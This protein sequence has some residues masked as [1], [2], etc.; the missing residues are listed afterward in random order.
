[1]ALTEGYGQRGCVK[2]TDIIN[3]HNCKN[4]EKCILFTM[5][6]PFKGCGN[7]EKSIRLSRISM[8]TEDSCHHEKSQKNAQNFR[9]VLPAHVCLGQNKPPF[10]GFCSCKILE[11]VGAEHMV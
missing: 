2:D 10:P 3:I 1:M 6:T 9:A 7:R 11:A 5:E 4:I 8:Y